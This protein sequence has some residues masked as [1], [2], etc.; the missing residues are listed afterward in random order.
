MDF[1]VLEAEE[2]SGPVRLA[3]VAH[4]LATQQIL[5]G[6]RMDVVGPRPGGDVDA[7]AAEFCF[8]LRGGLQGATPGRGVK[9]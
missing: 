9:K 7:L 8:Y 3:S 2:H 4:Q 1:P 6:L 5:H